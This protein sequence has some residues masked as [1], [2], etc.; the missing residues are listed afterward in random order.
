MQS[1]T[2]IIHRGEINIRRSRQRAQRQQ[3]LNSAGGTGNWQRGTVIE[4]QD[5]LDTGN[6]AAQTAQGLLRG[7]GG[8]SL[9]NRQFLE[10][11]GRVDGRRRA[12]G[13]DINPGKCRIRA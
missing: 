12:G 4:G 1:G 10:K 3:P 8:A 9:R 6:G 5:E 2:G 13:P 11:V 7:L